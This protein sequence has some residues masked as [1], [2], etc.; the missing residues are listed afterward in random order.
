MVAGAAAGVAS[1]RVDQGLPCAG[2]SPSQLAL[3]APLLARAEPSSGAGGTSV[4]TYLREG[5]K[6]CTAAVR[7]E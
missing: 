4:G 6:C 7:E 2:H 1:L 3:E 5:K